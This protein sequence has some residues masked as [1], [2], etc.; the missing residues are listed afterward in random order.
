MESHTGIPVATTFKSKPSI[1]AAK[2]IYPNTLKSEE[3]K[4]DT[5]VND[6]DND[7][8]K[9]DTN[10]LDNDKINTIVNDVKNDYMIGHKTIATK[11][12]IKK[13]MV[14]PEKF[15]KNL[16]IAEHVRFIQDLNLAYYFNGTS[17][18]SDQLYDYTLDKLKEIKPNHPILK[19]IGVSIN[20]SKR[21]HI[22]PLYMMSMNKIKADNSVL[23]KW[24]HQYPPTNIDIVKDKSYIVSDKLDGVS[25]MLV[26]KSDKIDEYNR[27]GNREIGDPILY[28]EPKLYLYT[29]GNG[30]YGQ[31]IS[32]LIPFIK[33]LRKPVQK[34]FDEFENK[35]KNGLLLAVRG[36]FIISRTNFEKIK[37]RIMGESESVINV[38]NVV[39]GIC[40][41]F[42]PDLG[43]VKYM[44]FVAYEFS[45]NT[46]V[47][48][49]SHN[50]RTLS[51]KYGF[52]VVHYNTI[53]D[54]ISNDLLS[55]TLVERRKDS[56][57]Y[58]DGIIVQYNHTYLYFNYNNPDNAFAFKTIITMQSAEVMVLKVEWN[59]TKDILQP[60][61]IFN[62][63]EIGGVMVKK[64]TGFNGKFIRDNCIG[65]GSCLE[66]MRRGDVI[67][68]IQTIICKSANEIP[69][70]P[71]SD[72]YPYIWNSSGVEVMLNI[73]DPRIKNSKIDQEI[74]LKELET[75]IT[76]IQFDGLNA[77]NIK[78]LFD[79]GI[80]TIKKF[81]NI[82]NSKDLIGIKS[83]GDTK[84]TTI[85][86]N[87]SYRMSVISPITMMAASNKLGRGFS[88]KKITLIANYY[89][90]VL[91]LIPESHLPSVKNLV[92]IKGIER[93]TAEQ[94][95]GNIPKYFEFIKENDLEK[96]LQL[97]TFQFVPV[98]NNDNDNTD[99]LNGIHGPFNGMHV[100]FTKIR[101]HELENII[102]EGGGTI[103]TTITSK[104]NITVVPSEDT[105]S[106]KIDK[107]NK[108]GIKIMSIDDFKSLCTRII[109][110]FKNKYFE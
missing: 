74:K 44:D 47:M 78:I 39:A 4:I 71:D 27:N 100:V 13:F 108:L 90:Q 93:K 69:A 55:D 18:I 14:N 101:D 68:H 98:T 97:T 36:E 56:E 23:S 89:P 45:S 7:N 99:I 38:R 54:E 109:D 53:G 10:V 70:M 73:S 77:G 48:H 41:S 25:G 57:Y 95:I 106:S 91:Q 51:D 86:K 11:T 21:K 3:F 20:Q 105:T 65:P 15:L 46:N 29:R 16:T 26:F 72:G 88:E 76:R 67:P 6:N 102:T 5:I 12:L 81:V 1:K 30:R 110:D 79:G 64:A 28:D 85:S 52:K 82:L 31:D 19:E 34:I 32:H 35:K 84:C 50:M 107:A 92:A 59:L 42:R 87:I 83:F 66:I 94:F 104:T 58:I 96:F 43:I 40:N 17:L 60:V 62:P 8:D 24:I 80:N 9:I 103:D 61:V 22:L 33:T 63:I 49:P 75:F 37:S 2:K